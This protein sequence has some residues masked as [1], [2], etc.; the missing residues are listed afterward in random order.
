MI[1]YKL[2]N[3]SKIFPS[4]QLQDKVYVN[5]NTEEDIFP[6]VGIGASAGGLNAFTQ[7]LKALPHR[8]WNGFCSGPTPRPKTCQPV[9]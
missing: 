3:K 6:I 7:L 1:V 4:K 8:Y 2:K 5:P 9:T